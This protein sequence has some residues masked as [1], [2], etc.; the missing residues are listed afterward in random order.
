MST[1]ILN[2]FRIIITQI[3]SSGHPHV[4]EALAFQFHAFKV[5][6]DQILNDI[7]VLPVCVHV[8]V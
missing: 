8:R 5:Q 6:Q 1:A 4:I 3:P 7:N 2:E